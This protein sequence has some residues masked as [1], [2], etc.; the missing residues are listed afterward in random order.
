MKLT[1]GKQ[2]DLLQFRRKKRW[3]AARTGESVHRAFRSREIS[4]PAQ[5]LLKFLEKIYQHSSA[6]P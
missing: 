4:L 3:I 1:G 2:P 5:Q 6:R